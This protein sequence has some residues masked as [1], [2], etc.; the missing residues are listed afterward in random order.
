M[1]KRAAATHSVCP[2]KI[3][4]LL[5]MPVLYCFLGRENPFFVYLLRF[6]A[7]K[8]QS[9]YRGVFSWLILSCLKLSQYIHQNTANFRLISHLT[10]RQSINK[11]KIPRQLQLH[12]F[13]FFATFVL[14]IIYLAFTITE[15]H[16][17]YMNITEKSR[18]PKFRCYMRIGSSLS[19]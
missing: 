10:T 8:F 6:F 11:L 18:V 15:L 16:Y 2:R 5:R 17:Y 7:I 3:R 9:D 19:M 14:Y 1:Q 13:C 12:S 4:T